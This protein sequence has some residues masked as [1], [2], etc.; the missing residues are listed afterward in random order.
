VDDLKAFFLGGVKQRSV[1]ETK[2]NVESSRSH[3]IFTV[4][5]K[6]RADKDNST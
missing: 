2:A 3:S 6:K 1:A 5:I 4:L